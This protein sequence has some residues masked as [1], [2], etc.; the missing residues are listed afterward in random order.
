MKKLIII[1]IILFTAIYALA[2]DKLGLC[3][4][5]RD[6]ITKTDLTEA[7]VYIY[8]FEGNVCDSIRSNMG[9]SYRSGVSDTSSFFYIS[10]PRVDSTYVID[11]RCRGY[12]TQT[13]TYQVKKIGRRETTR[14]MGVI[15]MER[16]PKMLKE[17]TVTT[18]KIKFY[19]K[20]DTV[21]YN[22]DAFQLA[23]GSMLDALIAQLPGAQLTTEGQ[24]KVN[25]VFVE[26]LLLNGKE[27]FD[28]NNNLM[29]ENIAA[30]TVR[31]IQVYEG[32]KPS[33]IRMGETMAPKVL[34]MDVRLKKEYNMGWI[35]NAQAGYG[36]ENRYLGKAFVNWFSN[37]TRLSFV[38]NVNNLNDNRKPGRDDTW[39]P[40]KQPQGTKEV[41]SLGMDYS[42]DNGLNT[43]FFGGNVS[44][45]RSIDKCYS[46]ALRTNFLPEGNTFENSYNDTRNSNT[47]VST[48]HSF[49]LRPIQVLGIATYLTAEYADVDNRDSGLSGAFNQDPENMT[50]EILDAIYSNGTTE[51]LENIINR[52]KTRT[53]GRRKT[54]KGVI[55]PQFI[56]MIPKTND[57]LRLNF[58]AGYDSHKDELWKDYVVNYGAEAVAADKR[59]QYFDNT[60]NHLL[61]LGGRLTYETHIKKQWYLNISY[62]FDYKENVKDSYMYALEHLEDMGVYGVVP[63]GYVAAFD[64]ANSYTS[65]TKNFEH[66]IKPGVRYFGELKKCMLLLQFMPE[67]SLV[68]RTLD[69][70]RN[71]R[72]YYISKNSAEFTLANQ[73]SAMVQLGLK[74]YKAGNFQYNHLL[75]YGYRV[76]PQLP[77]LVDMVDVVNDSDPLNIYLGN[78]DLKMQTEH[79]HQINWTYR[80][81]NRSLY[82][83]IYISYSYTDNALTRGYTYDTGTGVRYNR[84]Y[85]VHGNNRMAA[86]NNFNW[87]F[88]HSK[89]FT[90]SS[91]TD[92]GLSH[93]SDMIGV[94]KNEPELTKINYNNFSENFKFTWNFAGQSIS[95]RCDYTHRHTSS[96]QPGFTNLD[97]DH[98]NYGISGQF[99]LPAGFSA[100]TDFTCYT[101]RGYGADYLDTTDPIWNLRLSYCPPRYSRWVFMADGFDL[102]HKLSNVNYAVT[103]SGR[104]ISYTNALPRYF[105]FSV[106]YRLNI[107]PKK[108]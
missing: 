62:G 54:Y 61:S 17:L 105:I 3:G 94:G 34:T 11:F 78:P 35:I 28:G 101:R 4:Y 108:R 70:W 83:T 29:L 99:K 27:F 32:Q 98:V 10:V 107:Q 6:A 2:Q 84:M 60:P 20:G 86:T 97:A 18:T 67:I 48:A 87:Q 9:L 74:K 91:M 45:N 38:G 49:H 71:D 8:D 39:T 81:E 31:D 43:K 41:V 47:R 92:I 104:T 44:F 40:E 13:L 58:T 33:S 76:N 1:S 64:P 30:Y 65:D 103:A 14:D 63:S 96:T 89:Q 56:F 102:L 59:R 19:N 36:T 72:T 51:L 69:Y 26:S 42:Y 21:V 53:D 37:T 90:I 50:A 73:Y 77:E 68:H 15:L 93:M 82:N 66:S 16:A 75:Q 46:T 100:S 80:P 55:S 25:G 7:M 5:V 57:N 22:A 79:Y 52:A 88:G 95:L 23:E 12:K 85:N 106:Q 24:I